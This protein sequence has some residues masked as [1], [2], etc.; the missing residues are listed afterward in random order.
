MI[1]FPFDNESESNQDRNVSSDVLAQYFATYFTDGVDMTDSHN[2]EVSVGTGMLVNVAPGSACIQG[3]F[4]REEA[5]RN[6]QI[7]AA[8]AVNLNRIDTV[9]ARRDLVERLID[10]K[11]IKGVEA[12]Q[13]Q[14]PALTRSGDIYELGLANVYVKGGVNE[15]TPDRITDTRLDTSRCG[16]VSFAGAKVDT[17]GIFKQFQ[18]ALDEYLSLVASAVDGT[19]AGNLQNQLDAVKQSVT[20]NAEKL[21]INVPLF[22]QS[23]GAKNWERLQPLTLDKGV[24]M[25][26]LTCTVPLK[27][28]VIVTIRNAI[29]T[30]VRQTIHSQDSGLYES[31]TL[32]STVVIDADN[33]DVEYQAYANQSGNYEFK[34]IATRIG[35]IKP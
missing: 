33:T 5:P 10:L 8:P 17:A 12:S 3:R 35:E 31:G 32:T 27:S 23:I 30:D 9:V 2:L 18:A 7:Q 11:V 21:V 1:Y 4:C 26:S 29:D 14:P 34:Y 24:W 6:L 20:T 22:G 13:P 25:I 16:V 28:G 19:T 15:I